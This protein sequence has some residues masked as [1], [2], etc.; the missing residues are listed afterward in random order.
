MVHV[1]GQYVMLLDS[2]G[3]QM[4]KI[5]SKDIVSLHMRP[6]PTRI[7]HSTLTDINEDIQTRIY[8]KNSKYLRQLLDNDKKGITDLIKKRQDEYVTSENQFL[9]A[10]AKCRKDKKN[11]YVAPIVSVQSNS[12]DS[13]MKK[14]MKV[15]NQILSKEERELTPKEKFDMQEAKRNAA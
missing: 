5:A 2:K 11:A 6:V 13:F 8:K 14:K 3:D 15:E 12:L 7:I 9:D 10:L 1:S 4:W